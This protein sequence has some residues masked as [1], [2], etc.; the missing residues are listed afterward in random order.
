MVLEFNENQFFDVA[1]SDMF[2]LGKKKK[3]KKMT[4]MLPSAPIMVLLHL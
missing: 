2:N 3:E 4:L 1:L